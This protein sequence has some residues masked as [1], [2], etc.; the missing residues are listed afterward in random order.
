MDSVLLFGD[1]GISY[2]DLLLDP[3]LEGLSNDGVDAVSNVSSGK[4][5]DFT[6]D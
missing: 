6:L 4:L 5:V 2:V 1:F 3:I